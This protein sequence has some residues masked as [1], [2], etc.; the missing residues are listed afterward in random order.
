MGQASDEIEADTAESVRGS[1]W[2]K[3]N[4]MLKQKH[5]FIEDQILGCKLTPSEERQAV[6]EPTSPV[7]V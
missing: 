6:I 4:Y 2:D 5:C 3:P 7:S 1:K